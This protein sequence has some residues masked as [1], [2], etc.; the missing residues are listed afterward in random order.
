MREQWR[1]F[2]QRAANVLRQRRLEHDLDAEMRS[3]LEMA[4]EL[5]VA[6][7]L[8]PQDARRE[9]LR[10]FGGLEQTKELYRE[11]RGLPMIETT[12]QD[13]R[14]GLRML[15]RSPGFSALAILCLTLGIGANAAV[16]SWVEGILFR[17]YPAV[18]HQERLL[19]LAGTA[20]GETGPTPLSWPDFVDLQRNCTLLDTFFVSKITGTTLSIGDRAERTI[21]SIVSANYFDAIG[22][23]PMLGRGF[24]PG[25]DTGRSAHPVV[26]ISYQLWQGRFKGDPQI[27]GRTQRLNGVIHTIVGVAPEGFYGTFVGWGMQFWVPASMEEIFE[28][29]GYKLEDRGA[30]WIE[31]YG[32]LKPG[33]TR[34]QAQEEI[35]A[36]AKR[37]ENDYPDTNRGRSVQL[38]PLWQTP[39][40][41]AGTL[42]P[43][44][45]I[46]LAVVFFVL[47]IAC[48]NVGNL[49]LVKSF[50]RRHEM[51]VRLAI[52]AGRGRL[53]RQLLTEGVIL[54]AF[55]AVGG[56][57]VAY[58]CRH[59]LVL[60]FPARAGV[61]MHL[62]GEIDWRVLAVSAGVCLIATLVVGLVPAMQ[63]G[64][65]DLAAA[66]K[67]DSAGVVGSR[68]RA[69]VR[70]GLVVVQ[71]SLSFVLLVGAGL[72]LQ[73]LQKIRTSSPGFSTHGVMYTTVD[74]VSAGYDAQRAQTFQD[75]LIERVK[76][77]PGV[78]SATF[79]RMTPLGYGTYSSS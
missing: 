30:R 21:G 7:G 22:V 27:I 58:W 56:L 13:L 12:L 44:L 76:A 34:E 59:A 43:T 25:E 2:V 49:L 64:K 4:V 5:N 14:F 42:L 3:H 79:A 71:V 53:L 19:A 40:N 69:L 32:R 46:M 31:S 73:S 66:L 62:P 55:G 70:S 15:R 63:S 9:A 33:V 38:W 67:A 20:R 17:P 35:S 45:E 54:S 72:L 52:G 16:F 68:G 28:A 18:S 26:V 61:A 37:L 51:T 57:L 48:A 8:S 75:E 41:N 50:A 29:G 65:I 10:I 74:L 36:V 60:L 78:E 1:T 11:Q 77:L 47:L 23:R 24:E 6:K 39:F